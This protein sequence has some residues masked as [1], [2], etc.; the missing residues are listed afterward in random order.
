[1]K[2]TDTWLFTCAGSSLRPTFQ[3]LLSTTPPCH[4]CSLVL[5]VAFCYLEGRSGSPGQSWKQ[6]W[7]TGS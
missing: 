5:W 1:M 3:Y 7:L 4:D 2:S 6:R